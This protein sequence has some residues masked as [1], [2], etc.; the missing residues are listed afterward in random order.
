MI[1]WVAS[2]LIPVKQ[3]ESH[4]VVLN[5]HLVILHQVD[6]FSMASWVFLSW[7]SWQMEYIEINFKTTT[8][9]LKHFYPNL[10]A[11]N[12]LNNPKYW[13]GQACASNVD[14][15][16]MSHN[17]VSDH[18]LH[19]LALIQQCFRHINR[20]KNGLFQISGSYCMQFYYLNTVNMAHQFLFQGFGR[21]QIPT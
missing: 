15:D 5:A 14:P 9:S 20:Q 12:C 16:Q 2:S 4:S 1:K 13:E 18:G 19:C 7:L 8:R 10:V 21:R 11:I 6:V 17:V 3:F